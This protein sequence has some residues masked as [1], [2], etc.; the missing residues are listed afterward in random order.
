[1][2]CHTKLGIKHVQQK[3][4]REYTFAYKPVQ[5]MNAYWEKNHYII[6]YKMSFIRLL[7]VYSIIV[8][9]SGV[10]N[11]TEVGQ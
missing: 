10:A 9:S 11:G 4:G 7:Y 8:L 1:M 2:L 3:F 5:E 6:P